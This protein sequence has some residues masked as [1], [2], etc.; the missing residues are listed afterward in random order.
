MANPAVITQIGHVD[1]DASPT[2]INELID[3]LNTV[4]ESNI[5][6]DYI[7]Y[8]ISQDVPGV[9]DRS[10]AWIQLDSQGRPIAIKI[11]YTG[12]GGGA[13][14]R[15]YNG[16]IGEIRMY[17]GDPTVDFDADGHGLVGGTYD[18][19]QLCNSKN[20]AP[21]LSDKF[22]VAAHMNSANNGYS[23][24]WV[25]AVETPATPTHSGGHSTVTLTAAQTYRPPYPPTLDPSLQKMDRYS[26]TD[27]NNPGGDLWGVNSVQH[28]QIVPIDPGNTTPAPIDIVNPFIALGFIIF[29]GYAP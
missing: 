29:Q 6:G 21:D 28:Q 13:W 7:P 24:D 15:V 26:A 18:G 23:T 11:W 19:W 4:I 5:Q 10:K 20:G 16:M 27:S 9:D 12:G 14:R 3:L 1:P 22:I 25:S 2:R 17:S 8:V